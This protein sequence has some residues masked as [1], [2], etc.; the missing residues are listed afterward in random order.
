MFDLF[1]FQY[2][3]T[4]NLILHIF[5]SCFLHE[6]PAKDSN[7]QNCI[8]KDELP[9]FNPTEGLNQNT[10]SVTGTLAYTEK[11]QKS[12]SVTDVKFYPHSW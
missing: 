4:V 12:N 6:E 11:L 2:W 7:V 1:F 9:Q 8:L 5:F 10:P 3:A